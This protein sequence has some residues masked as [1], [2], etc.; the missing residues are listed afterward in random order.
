MHTLAT[1]LL[2]RGNWDEAA[3]LARTFLPRVEREFDAELWV[4]MVAF[5]VEALRHGKGNETAELLDELGLVER[6]QPIYVAL[7]AIGSG[8]RRILKA[9]APMF[10]NAS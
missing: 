3:A 9:V 5:F 7:L 4:E 8:N 2:A 10:E 1:I 6:W